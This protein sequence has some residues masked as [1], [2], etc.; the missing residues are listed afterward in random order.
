M[1]LFEGIVEFL[2]RSRQP[3]NRRNRQGQSQAAGQGFGE[4]ME[5]RPAGD[6]RG[7]KQDAQQ[8]EPPVFSQRD[9]YLWRCLSPSR[10]RECRGFIHTSGQGRLLWRARVDPFLSIPATDSDDYS[11]GLDNC[12][13]FDQE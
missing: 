4:R 3:V 13:A 6:N 5:H 12:Y 1:R 10:F 11:L 8:R 7:H 9:P 2:A